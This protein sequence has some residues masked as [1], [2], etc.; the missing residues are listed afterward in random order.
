MSIVPFP[1]RIVEELK[2]LSSARVLDAEAIPLG[3]ALLCVSCDVIWHSGRH[4]CPSCDRTTSSLHVGRAL[5]R[6]AS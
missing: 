3:Q 4:A 6:R 5:S 1:L 2:P